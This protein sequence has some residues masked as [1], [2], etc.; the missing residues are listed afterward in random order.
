MTSE[1]NHTATA[2]A[3]S[4]LR[5]AAAAVVV[6]VAL[7]PA[8]PAQEAAAPAVTVRVAAADDIR[9][10]WVYLARLAG[11]GDA[12]RDWDR[13]IATVTAGRGLAGI[14]RRRPAGAYGWIGPRGDDGA[15]VALVPVS[16]ERAFVDLVADAVHAAP[17]LGSDGVY[18]AGAVELP[19][20]G[21]APLYFRIV[22]GW[23]FVTARDRG[24]LADGR[25]VSP[26]AVL[27]PHCAGGD[28]APATVASGEA[29]TGG[30]VPGTLASG[31][32]ATGSQIADGLLAGNRVAAAPSRPAAHGCE[33]PAP[34]TVSVTVDLDR[35][36]GTFKQTV[37]GQLEG[38]LAEVRRQAPPF[39]VPGLWPFLTGMLDEM[40]RV[41]ATQL[42]EGADTSLQLDLDRRRGQVALTVNI[43]A[44]P[45]TAMAAAI[46]DFSQST[47]V[48]AG[49]LRRDAAFAATMNVVMLKRESELLSALVDGMRQRAVAAGGNPLQRIAVATVFDILKP[50]LAAAEIDWTVDLL[51]PGS[52]GL[53]NL[54]GA[55][56]V[57]DGAALQR[58]F[59]LAP[60]VDPVTDV[61]FVGSVGGTAIHRL[62]LNAGDA[63]SRTFGG[64]TAYVA[65]RDDAV[66][67]AAG[68]RGSSLV[69]EAMPVAAVTSPRI[70]EIRIAADRVAPLSADPEVQDAAHSVFGDDR[71]DATIRL[72]VAGGPTLRLR[73]V[74]PAKVIEFAGAIGHMQ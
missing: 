60:A 18:T 12:A 37:L 48:T 52:D 7:P 47:S 70:S 3:V 50:T 24:A 40:A 66:L 17:G 54:L 55:V 1:P 11:R 26:D 28:V 2:A 22:R 42:F 32:P 39:D 27:G 56:K 73:L 34:G 19:G 15:V 31:G 20:L 59:R 71:H 45:G 74:V 16:G 38:N 61:R 25:L 62:T 44:R 33:A 10:G 13:L 67:V 21:A 51:G 5:S 29:V 65:F 72:T 68:P 23:A 41:M 9:D 4:M 46:A 14:D 53:Y 43:A 49:L 36:P 6:A 58:M 69:R 8:A 35:V 64:N 63:F 30:S 57:R